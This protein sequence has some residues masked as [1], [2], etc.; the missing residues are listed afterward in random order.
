MVA[1]Q[2]NLG[3]GKGRLPVARFSV[4][5]RVKVPRFH[6]QA[7]SLLWEQV[8]IVTLV[9]PPMSWV[10]ERGSS[11]PVERQYEVRFDGSQEAR[12]VYENWLE[13]AP[14]DTP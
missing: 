6:P 3:D 14:S 4:D 11:Q 2:P 9:G 10:G 7:P 13:P 8:G 12:V 1:T 5:A